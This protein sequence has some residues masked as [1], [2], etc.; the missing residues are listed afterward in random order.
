MTSHSSHSDPLDSVPPIATV[1]IIF[2]VLAMI[3]LGAVGFFGPGAVIQEVASEG[4][5]PASAWLSWF[6]FPSISI[7]I[8]F[9]AFLS[10]LFIQ[11]ASFRNQSTLLLPAL[12]AMFMMSLPQMGTSTRDRMGAKERVMTLL[13][14]VR[15]SGH[16]SSQETAL[17][18][19][20]AEDNQEAINLAATYLRSRE[21]ERLMDIAQQL[22]ADTQLI[23]KQ[24]FATPEDA[25]AVLEEAKRQAAPEETLDEIQALQRS[26]TYSNSP[27][28][29]SQGVGS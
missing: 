27:K 5:G 25:Q 13:L 7:F 9:S 19:A 29:N 20:L 15:K 12:L 6:F 23:Q 21:T 4:F 28:A 26:Q 24:G 8:L 10:F 18:K 1:D 14:D 16:V 17:L 2:M 3:A 22:G 11:Q